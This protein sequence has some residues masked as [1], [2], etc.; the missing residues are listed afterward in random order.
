MYFLA[1][2]PLLFATI[3]LPFTL[4]HGHPPPSSISWATTFT[5]SF[6]SVPSAPIEPPRPANH[7]G[8][9]RHMCRAINLAPDIEESEHPRCV[10][11]CSELCGNP[12]AKDGRDAFHAWLTEVKGKNCYTGAAKVIK[13]MKD[14]QFPEDCSEFK[15]WCADPKWDGILWPWGVPDPQYGGGNDPSGPAGLTWDK[16]SAPSNADIQFGQ[17]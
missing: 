10:Y 17:Q 3:H 2:F 4:S 14:D 1:L 5:T 12:S 11:R 16:G 15:W 6:Q 7:T 9:L 13:C 8:V